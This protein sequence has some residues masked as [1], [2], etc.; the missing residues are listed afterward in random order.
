MRDRETILASRLLKPFAH[1]FSHPALWHLNRRTAPR[2]LAVGLFVAFAIPLGQLVLAGLVAVTTRAVVPLAAA[3]TLVSNPV[4]FAPIY[5]AAYRF[6]SLLLP[7]ASA[8]GVG[9]LSPSAGFSLLDVPLPRLLGSL[10]LR[11][12]RL[13]SGTPPELLYGG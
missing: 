3:S 1:L 8:E 7:A 10:H 12:C 11:L 9:Q 13:H 5:L 6:G 4:T 2:A